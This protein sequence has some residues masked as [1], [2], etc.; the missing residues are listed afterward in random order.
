M[1]L[2]SNQAI[3]RRWYTEVLSEGNLSLIDSLFSP[4]YTHHEEIVPGGWPRGTAGAQALAHTY[5][6]ASGDIRYTIEDQISAGDRVVTRWTAVGTHTGDF[7]GAPGSGRSF[8]ITGI[9]IERLEDGRIA[10]TWSNWDL[11]GLLVQVGLAPALS[12]DRG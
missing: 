5:R 1:N 3:V 9:S 7:L 2:E 11:L 4:G 12:P 6:T 8:M 10:E